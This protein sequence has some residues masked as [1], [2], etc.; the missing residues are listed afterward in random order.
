MHIIFFEDNKTI[1]F[2]PLA[3]S[4]SVAD[5]L[6]GTSSLTEEAKKS[7]PNTISISA[8]TL[9]NPDYES[10]V[11]EIEGSDAT[12]FAFLNSRLRSFNTLKQI[13][14]LNTFYLS[15]GDIV[16]FLTDKREAKQILKRMK[17]SGGILSFEKS[18]SPFVDLGSSLLYEYI[19]EMIGDNKELLN[20]SVED[21]EGYRKQP[22]D[23]LIKPQDIFI[24]ETAIISPFAVLDASKGA[25]YIDEDVNIL[26]F[27]YLEGPVYIGKRTEVLGGR[28][29]KGTSIGNDCKVHGE[30]ENSIIFPYTNKCHDGYIGHSIIGSWV[31]IGAGTTTSDLK[32]NYSQVRVQLDLNRT[33]TTTLIKI[34]SII[35]DHTKTAIHTLLNTGTTIGIGCNIFGCGLSPKYIP[36]FCWYGVDEIKEYDLGNLLETVH[37]VMTRRAYQ[38]IN[39]ELSQ[40]KNLFYLTQSERNEFLQRDK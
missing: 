17:T 40:L 13:M 1:N 36:S 22:S 38:D 16:G 35:G 8:Y 24:K 33:Y 5:F 9:K 29:G 32:N 2:F 39:R 6:I 15:E 28:I 20:S 34:G 14:K 18:L 27:T 31:N 7:F 25:I 10:I 4:H 23:N 30:I 21:W 11:Q 19:W 37:V 3:F 26:P 12:G